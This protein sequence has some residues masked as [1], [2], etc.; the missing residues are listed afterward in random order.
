MRPAA[1]IA[2]ILLTIFAVS[3]CGGSGDDPTDR[4]GEFFGTVPVETPNQADFARMAAG[5]IGSYHLQLS[6]STIEHSQGSYDWSVFDEVLRELARNDIQPIPYVVGTPP[7][8]ADDPTVPPTAD[9]RTFDAWADFLDAAA[10]RYGPDGDFWE[11][12]ATTDPGVEPAPLR[13]WEIWNEPNSSV[14]WKPTPDP[15]AYAMLL[16]RSARVIEKVD[17]EAEIMA[18]G[19]F[20]TPQSDGAIKSYDFLR[21][22]YGRRGITDVVDIVGLHPYGPRVGDVISQVERT[23]G[24]VDRAGDDAGLWVTELGWGSDPSSGNQLAKTPEKQAQLLGDSFAEL[25]DRRDEWGLRGVVWFTWRD[26]AGPVGDC[27]WCQAAGL[28]DPDRDSKP[29]WLAFTDLTGGD[30]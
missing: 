22:L 19:M 6:W 20:A 5:G 4:F 13:T 12:L 2:A 25:Y 16:K 7:G 28:V 10:R 26:T 14:F 24:A 18:A 1:A 3:A 30:P 23:R 21:D 27:V 17:P 9:E 8:Y 15:A 11:I 29:S